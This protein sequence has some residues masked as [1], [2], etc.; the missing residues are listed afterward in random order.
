M[1]RDKMDDSDMMCFSPDAA[2]ITETS[3]SEDEGIFFSFGKITSFAKSINKNIESVAQ[4]INSGAKALM[5]EFVELEQLEQEAAMSFQE[6][7]EDEY[8]S[9]LDGSYTSRD[10]NAVIRKLPFPWEMDSLSTAQ[11]EELKGH[12]LDLSKNE[13]LLLHPCEFECT[14]TST[15][16]H[17]FCLDEAHI[18]LINQLMQLDPNLSRVY[19][20]ISGRKN[21]NEEIFWRHYF[22]QCKK[23]QE[24]EGMYCHVDDF[25]STKEILVENH[26]MEN[27]DDDDFV[28]IQEADLY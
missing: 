26:N 23:L 28:F 20:K 17:T 10:G 18:D 11:Q 12:V 7:E 1:E 27:A 9:D 22:Y 19:S 6:Q 16:D 21:I 3:S 15:S 14:S 5:N 25:D 4:T 13:H 8:S 24:T 2:S